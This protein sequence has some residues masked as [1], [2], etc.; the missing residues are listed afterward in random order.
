M[1]IQVVKVGKVALMFM[2][3][4]PRRARAKGVGRGCKKDITSDHLNCL[5][6]LGLES[7]LLEGV[8]QRWCG[9]LKELRCDLCGKE[10]F[11]S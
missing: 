8:Q 2:P 3:P 7:G 4:Y 6:V 11:F 10:F 1:G 5:Q 9:A